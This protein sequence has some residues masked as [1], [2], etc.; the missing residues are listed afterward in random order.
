M[1]VVGG[2]G[3]SQDETSRWLRERAMLALFRIMFVSDSVGGI[4]SVVCL[5]GL[6][7]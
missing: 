2:G 1:V 6:E 7:L 3:G 4:L 5:S